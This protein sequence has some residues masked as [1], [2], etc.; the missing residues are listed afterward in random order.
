MGRNLYILAGTLGVLSILSIVLS[1]TNVAAQPGSPGDA[2]LWRTSSLALL[3]LAL[4][5]LLAGV[6]SSLFEQAERRA[7]DERR[8]ELERRRR[9]AE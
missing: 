3:S 9:G 4:I 5:V 8:R 6:L 1:F 2:A 7:T